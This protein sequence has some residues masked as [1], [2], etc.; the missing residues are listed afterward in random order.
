MLLRKPAI[1]LPRLL[2]P[3]LLLLPSMGCTLHHVRDEKPLP[4]TLGGEPATVAVEKAPG[5]RGRQ[6]ILV[7]VEHVR[8]VSLEGAIGSDAELQSI[9]GESLHSC[10]RQ[11]LTVE[12]LEGS[13]RLSRLLFACRYPLGQPVRLR[14]G[15]E[16]IPV[17]ERGGLEVMGKRPWLLSA[18]VRGEMAARV[19]GVPEARGI[20]LGANVGARGQVLSFL[21]VGGRA[22]V[23]VDTQRGRGQFIVGPEV[24]YIQQ[25]WPCSRCSVEASA[26]YLL[27]YA[28]GFAH[29]PEVDARCG[30][31]VART[32]T[33][34]HG[35]EGGVGYRHLFGPESGGALIFT[36]SYSLQTALRSWAVPE[37]V[38]ARPALLTVPKEEP[39]APARADEP[40]EAERIP[41]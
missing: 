31:R 26:S 29:G 15:G 28:R 41:L 20:D 18:W 27:G 9:G 24:S 39:Q 5:V 30:L 3:L 23:L 33:S 2:A 32:G 21:G 17:L 7:S 16:L 11:S 4:I 13:R 35:I 22:D 38:R 34:W 12:D 40:E 1:S 37:R 36:L 8:A 19:T 10:R 14:A 6:Q 25:G